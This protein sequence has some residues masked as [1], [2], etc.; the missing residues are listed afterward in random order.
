MGLQQEKE[1][2]R[3]QIKRQRQGFKPEYTHEAGRAIAAKV[4]AL[5]QYKAAKTVFL[6][7]SVGAEVDTRDI[8]AAALA[9]GKQ[10]CVPKTMGGGQMNA[11][12]IESVSQLLPAGFGLLE[13]ADGTAV[14]PPEEI[15]LVVVPCLACDENGVRLGYGGGYYDRWLRNAAGHMVCLCYHRLLQKKLPAGPLDLPVEMV[16]TEQVVL[17]PKK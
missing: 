4:L 1:N 16:V 12:R 3:K 17:V 9:D 13:P 11:C 15:D 6:Y 10:V 7:V 5:P 2:L 14:M 8:L